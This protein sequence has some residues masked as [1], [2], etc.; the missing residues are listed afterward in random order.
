M[1]FCA[2]IWV[3]LLLWSTRRE[4]QGGVS[5]TKRVESLRQPL[6]LDRELGRWLAHRSH[7]AGFTAGSPPPPPLCLQGSRHSL[8]FDIRQRLFGWCPLCQMGL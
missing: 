3:P 4:A 7:I 2:L 1:R 6:H 5:S 8:R